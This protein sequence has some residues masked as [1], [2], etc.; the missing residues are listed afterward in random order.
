[1]RFERF[2]VH[3]YCAPTRAALLTGRWPLRR[4][5]HGVT[6][7]TANQSSPFFCYLAYNAPHL[8]LQVPDRYFDLFKAQGLADEIAAED[9][10]VTALPP[11]LSGR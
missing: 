7:T 11:P 1:M 8:P 2:Y 9:R 5:S 3:S 10:T 4:G 6:D